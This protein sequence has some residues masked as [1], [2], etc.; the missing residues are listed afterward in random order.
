MSRRKGK[1]AGLAPQRE[2]YALA[3]ATGRS[4]TDAARDAGYGRPHEAGSRAEKDPAVR[5][6]I[7]ALKRASLALDRQEPEQEPRSI[8]AQ[9]AQAAALPAI[10]DLAEVLTFETT[11]MR[12]R[13]SDILGEHGEIDVERVRQLPAGVLRSLKIKSTTDAEGQVYAQ[14]EVRF[15]SA[16]DAAK[17]LRRHHT[18]MDRPPDESAR[19]LRTAVVEALRTSPQGRRLLDQLAAESVAMTVDAEAK[20]I[21]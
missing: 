4:I 16:L 21:P 3:R 20:R 10:A 19:T 6:R 7:A 12:H 14:H 13:A 2:A 17:D 9:E 5:A 1:L 15:E 8:V 11:V 18:G